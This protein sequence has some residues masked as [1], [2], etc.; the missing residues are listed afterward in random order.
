[1]FTSEIEDKPR[2]I[3]ARTIKGKG[4]S[5]CEGQ[6]IWHHNVLTDALYQQA[7]KELL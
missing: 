5:F 6:Y 1:M 2:A 4:V 3:I 7:M